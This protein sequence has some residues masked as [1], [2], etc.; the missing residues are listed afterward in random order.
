M[1]PLLSIAVPTYN[2]AT[3]LRYGLEIFISQIDPEYLHLV[4]IVVVD[5]CS[6]DETYEVMSEISG[7]YAFISYIRNSSNIG[8]EANLINC[9][10]KCTGRYLWIFGDDDFL[11]F[12]TSLHEI[13]LLLR[14]GTHPFYIINRTRRSFDLSQTLTNDWMQLNSLENK[15]YTSLN[16]FCCQW[17]IISII[18]FISVNIF[19]REP[20]QKINSE[21]YMGVMYPQLGMMLEAFG[22]APCLLIGKPLVCHRTQTLEE[23]RAALGEKETEKKFMSDYKQRD[24]VYFSFRLIKFLEHLID[25][26]AFSYDDLSG[27]DEFVFANIPLKEFL[28]KNVELSVDQNIETDD[29]T[30]QFTKLFF[31]KLDV[32]DTQQNRLNSAYKRNRRGDGE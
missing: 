4:E 31:D 24:A 20:F 13:L 17:G 30:W 29:E 11:E 6:T 3:Q 28:L 12:D 32:I 19:L 7:N 22:S 16:K 1:K 10:K 14:K 2:R 26:G 25:C 8:L 18:G 21:K 9:T 5:D 23:K 15:D 27:M